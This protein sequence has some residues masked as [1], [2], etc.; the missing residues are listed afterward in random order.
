MKNS[1]LFTAAD[2]S[3]GSTTEPKC[4][5]TVYS[6]TE[7]YKKTSSNQTTWSKRH[8]KPRIWWRE[9][10]LPT[11]RIWRSEDYKNLRLH[12]RTWERS[13]A[14]VR[15]GTRKCD[16]DL[17]LKQISSGNLTKI[18]HWLEHKSV[19]EEGQNSPRLPGEGGG[20]SDAASNQ[21]DEWVHETSLLKVR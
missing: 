19:K 13:R 12:L 18:E 9:P 11:A 7:K 1:Y 10:S 20:V 3:Q 8:V 21:W 6:A 5:A 2:A 15:A 16:C 14:P 17:C 4:L